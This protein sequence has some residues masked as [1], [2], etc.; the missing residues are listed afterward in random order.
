VARELH[1]GISQILV[2][3]RYALDL[4]GR[5]LAMGDARAAESLRKG[6]DS[7]ATAIQEVRRISR[8]LRPGALDDLG[9]GP[10][11]KTLT[12]D[13]AARTGIKA[14]LE[15]VVFRNRL[16]DEAKIALFRI[17]QEALTNIERH[18]AATE[19]QIRLFGHR[20]GATLRIQ[21]NGRGFR[22]DVA[23]QGLGLRNMQERVEQLGGSF[24]ILGSAAGTVIEAEVPLSHLLRPD[25]SSKE[26]A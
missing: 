2:S 6:Q 26:S 16:D 21:D 4:A 3:A 22:S 18:A 19:V 14:E 15:T 17:A 7:L 10:A 13:F 23:G 5:R 12:G 9:L 11:L 25:S 1:D 20:R 8:D 24:R